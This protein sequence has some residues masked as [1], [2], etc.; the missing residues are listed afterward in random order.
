M[1][2]PSMA[3][4]PWKAGFCKRISVVKSYRSVTTQDRRPSLIHSIAPLSRSW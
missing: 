4:A 3:A 1:T 2:V